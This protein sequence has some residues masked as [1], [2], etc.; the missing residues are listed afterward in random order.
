MSQSSGFLS[1]GS[2]IIASSTAVGR[3]GIARVIQS[4]RRELPVLVKTSGRLA[5]L[6]QENLE[7]VVRLH[8]QRVQVRQLVLVIVAQLDVLRLQQ[9]LAVVVEDD[10][11]PRNV[12]AADIR[13]KH[14]L[15]VRVTTKVL[16]VD[17]APQQLDVASAAEG[18]LLLLV[19][20]RELQDEGLVLARERLRQLRRGAVA[21]EVLRG[22][23][24]LRLLLIR[25]PRPRRV[26]P[27]TGW[28][29][30][31]LPLRGHPRLLPVGG[32]EG[33]LEEHLPSGGRCKSS[34][35]FHR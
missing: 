8:D 2:S 10:V 34:E 25:R 28:T 14:D 26:S 6:V 19:L 13:A 4:L 27:R 1:S 9:V 7:G 17:V 3:L 24:T 16:L 5:L 23:D 35:R 11:D 30:R 29:V 20:H 12:V 32:R 31:T 18:A 22:G 15:V 33:L 21:V